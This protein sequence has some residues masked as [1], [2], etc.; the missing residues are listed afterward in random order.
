ML[1]YEFPPLGGGAAPVTHELAKEYVKKGHVV[2]V[3][4]MHFKGLKKFEIIEGVNIYRIECLRDRKEISFPHELLSFVIYAKKFLKKR[5]K[6]IKYDINH[7]HFI[8]PTGLISLWLKK[9][10]KLPFIVTAHGSDVPGY[11]PDRFKLLHMFTKPLLRKIIKNA[12][13]IITPSNYLQYLIK[14]NIGKFKNIKTIPNGTNSDKFKPQKKKNIIVSSGRLLPR[15]GFQY[16]IR[17]VSDLNLDYELHILGD[18]PYRKELERLSKKSKT[19]VEFHGWISNQS[20]E[21]KNLLEQAKIYCLASLK[22]N[23]SISLLEA[24]SAGCAVITTN[25]SGCPETVGDAGL[26]VDA[27]SVNQIR[28][29]ILALTKDSKL[30]NKYQKLSRQR[31]VKLFTWDKIS[32]NYLSELN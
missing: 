27:K 4:T 28:D 11:N 22:E 26:L 14:K 3:V 20:D 8:L 1:N 23:A 6:K 18:G 17:A 7:T 10:Y 31:L 13:K 16:L 30:M 24:M 12:K 21:Y 19:K 15:K 5:L 2:D 9:H 29:H 32:E 25:I